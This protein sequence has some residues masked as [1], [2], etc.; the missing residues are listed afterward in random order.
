M[1]AGCYAAGNGVLQRRQIAGVVV[2]FAICF[3]GQRIKH[4]FRP[5][6]HKR[7]LAPPYARVFYFRVVQPGRLPL[8]R[9]EFVAELGNLLVLNAHL[10]RPYRA[11]QRTQLATLVRSIGT[12][13][14]P[15]LVG[16][17]FNAAP[18]SWTLRQFSDATD[19][20]AAGPHLPSWPRRVMLAGRP[21]RFPMLQL[22]LDQVWL[23]G[24]ATVI[25]AERGTDI[26]SDHMPLIVHLRLPGKHV[27]VS[28]LGPRPLTR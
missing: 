2:S 28:E 17:D 23:S 11:S 15:V 14:G 19:L 13:P 26:G 1:F 8:A 16:G 9:A 24:E 20:R 21:V 6:N 12:W 3:P 4:T 10:T 7:V 5:T 27:L 18:W 25:G 22:Q